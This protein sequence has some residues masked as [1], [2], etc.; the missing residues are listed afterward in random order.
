MS[1]ERESF[2]Q[3]LA[4]G[5]RVYGH[6]D[7]SYWRDMGRPDDFVHGSADLVRGVAHSPL[8]EGRTGEALVDDSAG[9]AGGV[10]LLGGTA[11]GRGAEIGPG[12]RIDG[13]VI[14]DGV[15]VEAGATIKDSIIA[16]GA[17]IGARCEL[18]GGMRIWPG[19]AI[20]DNGV[21]FSSDA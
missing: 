19:V 3:F 13:S 4:E 6:V 14:F 5:R 8:L 1:V 20:P 9:V 15:T 17:Q 12:C 21:R 7:V 18:Q 16:E 2:P 10:I 11:V